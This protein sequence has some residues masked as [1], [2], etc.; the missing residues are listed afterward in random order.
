MILYIVYNNIVLL[1]YNDFE[2][3]VVCESA[4]TCSSLQ[5]L[6]WG[7]TQLQPQQCWDNKQSVKPSQA[8]S[9]LLN[10]KLR[11]SLAP[12][13]PP[14][15]APLGKVRQARWEC[16]VGYLYQLSV[17]GGWLPHKL[18]AGGGGSH[19]GSHPARLLWISW[20]ELGGV[21]RPRLCKT[22]T[23]VLAENMRNTRRLCSIVLA[24]IP[25][26]SQLMKVPTKTDRNY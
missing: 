4:V 22:Q 17:R 10:I 16:E 20:P 15:H 2:W 13:S 8:F 12:G 18:A 7:R 23:D 14:P 11:V 21:S 26:N 3:S 1:Y 19:Q 24:N 9:S 6:Q 5:R 25:R